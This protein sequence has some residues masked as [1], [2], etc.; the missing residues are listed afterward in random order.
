M[1]LKKEKKLREKRVKKLLDPS[2]SSSRD[3]KEKCCKKFKKGEAKRCKNCPCYDLMRLV[4][5]VA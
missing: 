4:K 1:G 3:Y 5:K 2:G